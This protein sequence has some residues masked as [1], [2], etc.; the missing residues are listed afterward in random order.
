MRIL[1]YVSW[2]PCIFAKL[3]FHEL[4]SIN[5]FWTQLHDSE[6]RSLSC[7]SQGK[8]LPTLHK[9]GPWRALNN[10]DNWQKSEEVTCSIL[11]QQ[12]L[13][14]HFFFKNLIPDFRIY[15]T[16]LLL[17]MNVQVL[18]L[19]LWR[20]LPCPKSTPLVIFLT[21]PCNLLQNLIPIMFKHGNIY[22]HFRL[23]L[24]LT[25]NAIGFFFPFRVK[26]C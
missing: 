7:R 23:S 12:Q 26:V 1:L 20:S 21:L 22:H 14:F 9:Y 18:C 13:W 17:I 11:S 5:E 3:R 16:R 15:I 8:D 25:N 19:C 24:L 10:R 2:T 6:A 4:N